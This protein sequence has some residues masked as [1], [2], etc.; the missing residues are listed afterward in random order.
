MTADTLIAKITI[1]APPE[2]IFAVLADPARHRAIEG[3]GWVREPLDD[4]PLTEAGQIFRMGMYLDSV[5]HYRMA[6][7]VRVFD[8]PHAISWEPGRD[9]DEGEVR[10]GGWT[11][12]YDMEPISQDETLVTLTYDWSAVSQSLRE[13]LSFP[14]FGPDHLDNSLRHLAELVTGP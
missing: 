4:G 11:W 10:F 7:K 8:P 12:R 3:T 1:A 2:A 9:T 5:G 14:P 6:N 13:R